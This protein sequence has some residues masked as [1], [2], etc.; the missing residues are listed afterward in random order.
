M[1]ES[2]S[3]LKNNSTEEIVS[4][5][6][7]DN[8]WHNVLSLQ[9]KKTRVERALGVILLVAEKQLVLLNKY[10]ASSA[11]KEV[12]FLY[13]INTVKS[14]WENV[15]FALALGKGRNLGFAFYPTRLVME[16]HLRLEYYCKQGKEGQNDIALRELMRL[17]KRFYDREKSEGNTGDQYKETYK[18]F[19]QGGTYPGIDNA[20]AG[21]DPFPNMRELCQQSHVY[22]TQSDKGMKLYF[23]YQA[24][25]ELTH[26][27]LFAN[28]SAR[29]DQSEYVR[30]IMELY[31]LAVNTLKLID[32]HAVGVTAKEVEE[33]TKR[34]E[35]II[36]KKI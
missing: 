21:D 15:Y 35:A 32:Y 6:D 10:E 20:R 36:K 19:A 23:A 24:L 27:K 12:G 8:F 9:Q 22:A 11:S 2:I 31:S 18:S 4:E 5:N 28:I 25:A 17:A 33:A 3:D 7:F 29:D 26:G 16:N 30:S 34:G 14:I 13:F 1:P